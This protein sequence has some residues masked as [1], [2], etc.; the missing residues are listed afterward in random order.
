MRSNA[1]IISPKIERCGAPAISDAIIYFYRC[2]LLLFA[3]GKKRVD[4]ISP[5]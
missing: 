4:K 1:H 3:V 5:R 2:T